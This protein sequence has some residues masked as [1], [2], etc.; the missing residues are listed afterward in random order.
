MS[1]A[2][3]IPTNTPVIVL[4]KINDTHVRVFLDAEEKVVSRADIRQ[5]DA[6]KFSTWDETNSLI[7]QSIINNPVTDLLYSYNTNQLVPEH[8]QY[9]PLIKML[10]SPN[11]RLLIADEVGLGKTIEAGMIL[12]EIDKR[13]DIEIALIVVP[14]SLTL[15]WKQEMLMRFGVD[16]E[17]QKVNQFKNFLKEYETYNDSRVFTKNIIVS[18]HSLRDDTIIEL[19]KDTALYIDVL[20]M[21][22]AHTF[23]NSETSTFESAALVTSLAEH[24]LF[25]SATP[26]QNKL[27]DLFNLLSLLDEDSFLDEEHFIKTIRP[28]SLIHQVIAHL[29]TRK[30]LQ[31]IQQLIENNDLKSL[32]VSEYQ[33]DLFQR[34]LQ[35]K[36][37]SQNGRVDYIKQFTEADNLSYIINRTK[38]KD[39]GMFI[40]REAV[41][42]TIPG[43]KAE[44]DF[45]NEVIEFVKLFFKYKNPKIPAGFITIMPERMASSCMIASIESFKQMRKT[46]KFFITDIDDQDNDLIDVDIEDVLLEKLDILIAKG[47]M[48]GEQ[49][50]KYKAFEETVNNLKA[51]DVKKMIVFSFFKK[52]LAYLEVKLSEKGF[53]VGKI[54]GDLTPE[55]RF[56][57]INEFRESKFDI[58]LSSEVGSEGLDMQFCN[59]VVNYDLPWNPMRVEQ[60]IGRIDRIGQEADKLLVFNLCIEG[61]IEDRILNRLY[62]KLNIFESSIGELEPIL[63]DIKT[64]FDIEK[65]VDLSDDDIQKKVELE[66]QSLIRQKKDVIE[67][68]LAMDAMLNDDYAFDE[69]YDEFI[70]SNK[71]LYV[72]R[73]SEKLFLDFLKQENIDFIT[74]KNNIFRLNQEQSKQLFE[75]LK[76]KMAEPRNKAIHTLQKR[77]LNKL[78]KAK[79]FYFAFTKIDGHDFT[80]EYLSLSHP[81]IKM[82]VQ[83]QGEISFANAKNSAVGEGYAVVYR[84]EINAHK[85]TSRLKTVVFNN[86]SKPLNNPDYYTFAVQCKNIA[87]SGSLEDLTEKMGMIESFIIDRLEKNIADQKRATKHLLNQKILALKEHYEK[88]RKHAKK[89]EEKVHNLDVIRMRRAQVENINQLEIKKIAALQKQMEVTGSYQILGVV[90][91]VEAN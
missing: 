69:T 74:L 28:N 10:Q 75:V 6:P 52:T 50:S 60:R 3:Y 20:I 17:I 35:E 62:S 32:N 30:S 39:V 16:F 31:D 7:L 73:G 48:I 82:V 78:R 21:D 68:N 27:S 64:V 55:E 51:Q 56:A 70:N 44:Q 14:S 26:M 11:N 41:S 45:Y 87:P 72:Q 23:R 36:F 33:E 79:N 85:K 84:E 91:L 58:L 59:V 71:E 66:A 61:T 40:P 81:M 13:E 12:Q 19:L 63:G 54:D 18:Y 9:R 86:A 42:H 43:T 1:K 46:K 34:F 80:L 37:L 90:K 67:Q 29:K 2:T 83:K 49:D 76:P 57:K 15:K 25:L 38:K 89:M 8:Y 5:E 53:R 4:E 24:I 22:E 47:K 65:M 88:K 77:I